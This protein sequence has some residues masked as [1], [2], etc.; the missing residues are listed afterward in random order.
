MAE[1]N[2]QFNRPLSLA[3][4][5]KRNSFRDLTNAEIAIDISNGSLCVINRPFVA[6]WL[7]SLK[8]GINGRV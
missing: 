4:R 3:S 7:K 6:E 2:V 1:V 8:S 5:K